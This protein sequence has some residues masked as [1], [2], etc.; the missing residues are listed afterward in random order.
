MKERS[1]SVYVA[2][3]GGL[4]SGWCRHLELTQREIW[5]LHACPSL[6][7]SFRVL[8]SAWHHLLA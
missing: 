3:E 5:P 2:A 1:V 6:D 8:V 7:L 4:P